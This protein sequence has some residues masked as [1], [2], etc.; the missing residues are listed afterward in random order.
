MTLDEARKTVTKDRPQ[1]RALF[2]NDGATSI[3]EYYTQTTGTPSVLPHTNELINAIT[4]I[5]EERIDKNTAQRIAETLR[6]SYTVG[7]ADHHGPVSHP[8][9]TNNILVEAHFKKTVLI[10]TCAG[11]SL[12]NSSYPRGILFHDATG[13]L[14]RLP[15]VPLS[16]QHHPVYGFK[17]DFKKIQEHAL[18]GLPKIDL[19]DT[20][21]QILIDILKNSPQTNDYT[22]FS[23]QLTYR[24]CQ[25]VLGEDTSVVYIDQETLVSDVLIQHHL[26]TDTPLF[27]ILF[28]TTVRTDFLKLWNGIDG[29]FDSERKAGTQLFWGLHNNERVQLFV[30]NDTLISKEGYAYCALTPENIKQRLENQTLYP[31]MALSFI[32]LTFYYGLR[33]DGGFCQINYLTEMKNAW[34]TLAQMHGFTS[35]T[36]DTHIFRGEYIMATIDT[37]QGIQPATLLDF[38][39][40]PGQKIETDIKTHIET[41]TLTDSLDAMMEEFYRITTGETIKLVTPHIEPLLHI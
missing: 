18:R 2:E 21:K 30:Y 35:A 33:T 11:I 4:H 15:F 23:T 28:D 10:L 26:T 40:Y 37:P 29:A 5:T 14:C 6:Q 31:S 27:K 22:T 25:L 9:F 16:K 12:D 38:L 3:A 13:T 24:L 8:F 41:I 39:L 17:E 7:T 19:T 32:V 20:Q 34:N 1:L 36:I